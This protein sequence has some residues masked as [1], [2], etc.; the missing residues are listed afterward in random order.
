MSIM[1]EPVTN[2]LALPLDFVWAVHP[3]AFVL[4]TAYS[5]RNYAAIL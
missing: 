4:H 3:D 5:R 1:T 2:P